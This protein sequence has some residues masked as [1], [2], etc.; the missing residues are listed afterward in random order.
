MYIISMSARDLDRHDVIRRLIRKEIKQGKAA[1]LLGISVRQVKRLKKR[2]RS[3]GVKGLV[4]GS[5]G[6]PGNRRLPE[7]TTKK[8]EDLIRTRYPDFSPVFATEKLREEHGI[9][10]DPKTIASVMVRAKL[11]SPPKARRKMKRF[12]WRPRRSSF[13]ELEQFDG[14]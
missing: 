3:D 10:H 1:E 12:S 9:D 13:G 6:K 2:V 11:W 5:R 7:E 4:H 14:S 8:I